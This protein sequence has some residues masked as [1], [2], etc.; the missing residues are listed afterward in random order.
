MDFL[1]SGNHETVAWRRSQVIVFHSLLI[2]LLT[3]FGHVQALALDAETASVT[4]AWD[5]SPS[6]GVM[7]YVVYVGTES[8]TYTRSIP[9][10]S[11]TSCVIDNLIRGVTYY[12]AVTAVDSTGLESDFSEELEYTPPP[13]EVTPP[14]TLTFSQTGSVSLSSTGTVAREY[15]VLASQDLLTWT[16]L[17]RIAAGPDGEINFTDDQAPDF[18]KRF[19]QFVEVDAP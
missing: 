17:A 12:I 13:A 4:V 16:N 7:G 19:Y 18:S 15:D 1:K 11:E 2:V 14:I 8:R 3:L 9:T 5:P 10:G 6:E